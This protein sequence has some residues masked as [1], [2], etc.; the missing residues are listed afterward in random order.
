VFI[1]VTSF[2]VWVVGP[3]HAAPTRARAKQIEEVR[4]MSAK[5]AFELRANNHEDR[6]LTVR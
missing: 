5:M 3:L 4:N 6:E 1:V 2:F